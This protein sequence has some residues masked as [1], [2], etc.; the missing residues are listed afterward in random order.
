MARIGKK[1]K[2]IIKFFPLLNFIYN[3][4]DFGLELWEEELLIWK[5]VCKAGCRDLPKLLEGVM[6]TY[7]KGNPE[8]ANLVT[9]QAVDEQLK[10]IYKKMREK[11]AFVSFGNYY[12]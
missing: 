4:K 10:R 1:D 12:R 11:V 2:I 3:I 9:F 5:F 7:N 6:R 8:P